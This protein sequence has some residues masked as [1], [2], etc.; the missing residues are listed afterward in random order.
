MTPQEIQEKHFHDTFRGYSHEEVDLFLDEVAVAFERLY[1][2]N[3]S[4]MRRVV[5]LEEQV[6]SSS[7]VSQ[8]SFTPEPVQPPQVFDEEATVT[9][10]T[11]KRMLLIA[12]ETADKAV[13]EARQRAREIQEQARARSDEL[14]NQAE[15]RVRELNSA[16][17]EKERELQRAKEALRK[18]DQQYRTSFR[19]FIESQLEALQDLPAAP[20]AQGFDDGRNA[21]LP[22]GP[23]T[24]GPMSVDQE[25]SLA[26]AAESAN[27]EL[28]TGAIQ[29][30]DLPQRPSPSSTDRPEDSGSASAVGS[31]GSAEAEPATSGPPIEGLEAKPDAGPPPEDRKPQA[32]T[33][34]PD[35]ADPELVRPLKTDKRSEQAGAHKDADEDKLIRELFWGD[36]D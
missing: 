24:A 10:T 30:L 14:I 23:S 7:Q 11:L 19:V 9:E 26:V 31:V 35:S 15:Q 8:A 18:F 33:S 20:A 4:F 13:Q 25:P 28:Q 27:A 12:Q 21:D 3:Q 6:K 32:S 5:D 1:R 22:L 29:A 17:I 34:A 16:K 2:E 36:E